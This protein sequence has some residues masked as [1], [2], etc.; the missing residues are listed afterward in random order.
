MQLIKAFPGPNTALMWFL[1]HHYRWF[2]TCIAGTVLI[3][4][5]DNELYRAGGIVV[6]LPAGLSGTS[7]LAMSRRGL[8]SQLPVKSQRIADLELLF[9][10]I[11]G[12]AG[13][14]LY[15]ATLWIHSP[16]VLLPANYVTLL[17]LAPAT[18]IAFRTAQALDKV[19]DTLIMFT[20]L[21]V[22][23]I[24][25][26]WSL[27]EDSKNRVTWTVLFSFVTILVARFL[28][29]W[30]VRSIEL[31]DSMPTPKASVGNPPTSGTTP[32]VSLPPR[33]PFHTRDGAQR[34]FILRRLLA[35]TGNPGIWALV[36]SCLLM[37]RLSHKQIG[38]SDY[39]FMDLLSVLGVTYLAVLWYLENLGA[40]R[41]LP[42]NIW[43][44]A[45]QHCEILLL[46]LAALTALG[47]SF[48]LANGDVG[49]NLFWVP[50]A[51]WAGISLAP[52]IVAA[53]VSFFLV[54]PGYLEFETLLAFVI[55]AYLLTLILTNDTI[56]GTLRLRA[57][58]PLLIPFALCGL[59]L[60]LLP[61][62]DFAAEYRWMT[63][64]VLGV[65]ITLACLRY[66][67]TTSRLPQSA[68]RWIASGLIVCLCISIGQ[69]AVR[70]VPEDPKGLLTLFL[71]LGTV[72]P[73]FLPITLIPFMIEWAGYG[74]KYKDP[75]KM[76]D[77]QRWAWEMMR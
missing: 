64:E 76:N 51:I 1:T 65:V 46:G 28:Y 14:L 71:G 5:Y 53:L 52:S 57:L 37:P 69:F 61:R 77:G 55:L 8:Q 17:L 34:W 36:F 13:I 39:F 32:T 21:S 33:P 68:A 26:G 35:L 7:I 29:Q 24:I 25:L 6:L 18:L 15:G 22:V 38:T 49:P 59:G 47:W 31:D 56:N 42:M 10:A 66:A 58:A 11:S 62:F 20:M 54:A 75:A 3:A 73:I 19:F 45:R 30:S 60:C 48:L 74:N 2:L 41:H 44:R 63:R 72:A 50:W 70:G 4:V 23:V 16:T 43:T 67:Q 40:V 27:C 9:L 12:V